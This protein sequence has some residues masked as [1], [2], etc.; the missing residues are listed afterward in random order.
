MRALDLPSEPEE[1]GRAERPAE[2]GTD[3]GRVRETPDPDE[4]GRVYETMRA[5]VSV[6]TGGAAEPARR[7]DGADRRSYWD[8]VPRFLDMWAD[9]EKRWP[10]RSPAPVDR[11]DDP[12]GVDVATAEATCR[13]REAEPGISADAQAIERENDR[14]GWLQ[15]FEFRLKDEDSLKEK[16]TKKLEAEP[17]MTAVEALHEVSDAIRYTYCFQL[18]AY[19]KGYYDINERLESRGHEMWFSKNWWT[20]REYKGINTRWI[21]PD[22]QRFEVQFHTQES[23]H[24]KH[25]VT[26]AAYERIRDPTTSRRELRELHEF[27]KEVCSRIR[28][29]DGAG[30]IPDF[31]KEGF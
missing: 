20:H 13:V 10:A 16:V 5:H 8:E 22:G 30:A 28:V 12:L 9:H 2:G 19:V 7:P 1:P 14:G 18:D 6:D 26:H 15:G 11:S 23:F 4:R 27:Q 25:H 29:P 24:A 3:R 17:R 31:R 21:S